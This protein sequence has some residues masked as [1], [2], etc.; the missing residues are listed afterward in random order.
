MSRAP[1]FIDCE[2]TGLVPGVHQ[3]WEAALITE[4]GQEFSWL[5]ED[6]RLNNADPHA[7]EV[8]RFWERWDVAGARERKKPASV[9]ARTIAK[10]TA[11]KVLVGSNPA[12]DARFLELLLR[13]HNRAPGW[14]YS[15]VDVKAMAAGWL[16]GRCA[17]LTDEARTNRL[18]DLALLPWSSYELSEACG[19]APPDDEERHTALGDARWVARWWRALTSVGEAS[20]PSSHAD[21]CPAS[22]GE[23]RC[24]CTSDAP[25]AGL[26]QEVSA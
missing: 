14:H 19:V 2:T 24:V 7:L 3:V 13:S 5:V 8:G 17:G 6:I 20:A 11:G 22:R 4:Y 10:L 12:F 15:V 16:H 23:I 1:V 9:V 25:P 26:A 21:G 18:D